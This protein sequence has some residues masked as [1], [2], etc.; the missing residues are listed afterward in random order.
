MISFAHA[1]TSR[2]ARALPRSAFL[3]HDVISTT[4]LAS[5]ISSS[6]YVA[7]NM[8][9]KV[10]RD[11]LLLRSPSE[12]GGF[13]KYE[14]AFR[15]RGYRALSI[16]V[17]ETVHT[18]IDKL[19]DI[20][21]RGGLILEQREGRRRGYAGVIMTSGRACEAWRIVVEQLTVG[22]SDAREGGVLQNGLVVRPHS[23]RAIQ[24]PEGGP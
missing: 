13:D 17:L 21:R 5:Q 14:E 2:A 15:A 16:P 4:Q 6:T 7:S 1:R 11:V 18:N 23:L 22:D 19:S 8:L 12:D 24:K 9:N 3:P 10:P 20:V